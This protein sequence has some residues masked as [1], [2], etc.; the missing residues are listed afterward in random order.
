MRYL[1]NRYGTKTHAP[2]T[3]N[4]DEMR[5]L[6]RPGGSSRGHGRGRTVVEGPATCSFCLDFLEEDGSLPWWAI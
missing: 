6:C 2:R 4:P 3:S 1:K 5:I